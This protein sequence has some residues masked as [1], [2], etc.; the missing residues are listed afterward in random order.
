[1]SHIPFKDMGQLYTAV[2]ANDVNWAFGSAATTGSLYRAGKVRFLAA[3]AP[4]R[5]AGYT[6]VPTVSESGGPPSFEV[7]AWIGLLAPRGTSK[8][9]IAK[10]NKDIAVA[11]AD[12]EVVERF[13]IF[14]Y[15][16]F[17]MTPADM[18]KLAEAESRKY[19]EIVKRSKIS[20]D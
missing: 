12:K 17:P 19:G 14:A 15:E 4:R 9:I 3:A 10:L 16:P 1:M 5:L 20:L 18:A 13:A 6:D 7:S 11:L 2:G 8:D